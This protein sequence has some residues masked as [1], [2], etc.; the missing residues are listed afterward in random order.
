MFGYSRLELVCQS[1]SRCAGL[2]ETTMLAT[3]DDRMHRRFGSRTVENG[4]RYFLNFASGGDE[5][6]Y[7]YRRASEAE[8]KAAYG[9]EKV[10]QP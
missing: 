2:R 3:K 4:Q 1:V 6:S 8:L 7:E 10:S 5:L 9:S